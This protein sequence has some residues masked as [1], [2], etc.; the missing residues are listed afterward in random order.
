MEF[1][2]HHY[3]FLYDSLSDQ[4]TNFTA[5]EVKQY[6]HTQVCLGVGG[7]PHRLFVLVGHCTGS[8]FWWG[9]G[10]LSAGASVVVACGLSCHEA[11]GILV[12]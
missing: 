10:L 2:I 3:S 6:I 7:E 5:R 4:E 12:A 11:C 1:F 8:L 9:T